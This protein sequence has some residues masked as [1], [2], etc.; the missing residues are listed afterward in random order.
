MNSQI[1]SDSYGRLFAVVSV[2]WHQHKLTAGDLLMTNH[3]IGAPL[4]ARIRLD[5]ILMIGAKDFSL[6][7]R[8]LL[9]KDLVRVEATVVEKSLSHSKINHKFKSKER[10]VKTS[11]KQQFFSYNDE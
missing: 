7:G 6:L 4:G 1:L 5:K 11:C 3:D 9:P 8:P 10:Y 2:G